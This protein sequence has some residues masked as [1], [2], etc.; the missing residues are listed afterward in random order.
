MPVYDPVAAEQDALEICKVGPCGSEF[1]PS[2]S[3]MV[4]AIIIDL[5]ASP[6]DIPDGVEGHV[7]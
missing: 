5:S 6:D 1:L 4:H 7:L 2:H 3:G